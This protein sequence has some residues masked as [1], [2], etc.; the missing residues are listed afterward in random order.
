V[1]DDSDDDDNA[2]DSNDGRVTDG[3]WEDLRF[4]G[5]MTQTK[6]QRNRQL[7]HPRTNARSGR[8]VSQEKRMTY[9]GQKP[10]SNSPLSGGNE[11]T[12]Q[13]GDKSE[14]DELC[15]G[16]AG[17]SGHQ[18]FSAD[19]N[20]SNRISSTDLWRVESSDSKLR[21][22]REPQFPSKTAM[23]R[24]R[25]FS[26]QMV[27]TT[28][29]GRSGKPS[30][31]PRC[32]MGFTSLSSIRSVSTNDE[33]PKPPDSPDYQPQKYR[34]IGPCDFMRPCGNNFE[35]RKRFSCRDL[36]QCSSTH[37]RTDTAGADSLGFLTK[38]TSNN[39]S[40]GS[41]ARRYLQTPS[42]P[43]RQ[44]P[45]GSVV[46]AAHAVSSSTDRPCEDFIKPDVVDP[47]PDLAVR[48]SSDRPVRSFI[49][50]DV[51]A[52]SLDDGRISRQSSTDRPAR[53]FNSADHVDDFPV[54]ASSH[55]PCRRPST[56]VDHGDPSAVGRQLWKHV[57]TEC[58]ECPQCLNYVLCGACNGIHELE[59]RDAD[60]CECDACDRDSLAVC[61]G[62]DPI[63]RGGYT[64][65]II[66]GTVDGG[67]FLDRLTGTCCARDM[68]LHTFVGR[69][70][71]SADDG[72]GSSGAPAGRVSCSQWCQ[73]EGP[74]AK[75]TRLRSL[76]FY[77]D[78]A[79][80]PDCCSS[81]FCG[82][83][84][85][86]HG[87][88]E[89]PADMSPRCAKRS[90]DDDHRPEEIRLCD[91]HDP[92]PHELLSGDDSKTRGSTADVNNAK[93][94]ALDGSR[95]TESIT[96]NAAGIQLS[97]RSG[98]LNDA[99]NPTIVSSDGDPNNSESTGISPSKAKLTS[100][101]DD[102][103]DDQCWTLVEKTICG[104]LVMLILI[105]FLAIYLQLTRRYFTG[106]SV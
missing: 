37:S 65:R 27:D 75:G 24:Q 64:S 11:F 13:F 66:T 78:C 74:R 106:V 26:R 23:Q 70:A 102:P 34:Y 86:V 32:P 85:S 41:L 68:D 17:F 59:R 97:T 48:D 98:A 72:R 50:A 71:T 42:E 53:L 28:D 100:S 69:G 51:A 43:Q 61:D 63:A 77:T 44:Q 40:A 10:A 83:C 25:G 1:S 16:A 18:D 105:V 80:C 6:K 84:C 88:P 15:D 92:P 76:H 99:D 4:V 46:T 58:T 31:R 96:D 62:S 60:A 35:S 56:A 47:P 20:Q 90:L 101:G 49:S 57:Y 89:E 104:V 3:S 8:R 36:A 5:D 81:C 82:S 79:D 93:A 30:A 14:T 9:S 38:G 45:S 22:D 94:A 73:E 39:S 54:G 67:R 52:S 87:P 55:D 103:D 91:S 12:G 19:T 33:V 95:L 29:S 2:H 7:R 21:C